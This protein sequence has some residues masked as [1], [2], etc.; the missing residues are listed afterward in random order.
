MDSH[1]QTSVGL[2]LKSL[3]FESHFGMS[4]VNFADCRYDIVC[5][6]YN[7]K[8]TGSWSNIDGVHTREKLQVPKFA[9]FGQIPT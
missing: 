1:A 6:W 5:I 4:I 7:D 3:H 2:R 9:N 8:F